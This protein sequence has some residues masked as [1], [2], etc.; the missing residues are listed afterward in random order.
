MNIYR[1]PYLFSVPVNED[2]HCVVNPLKNNAIRV[3]NSRQFNTL[4]QI[5]KLILQD[6]SD[7][8]KQFV[9]IMQQDEFLKLSNDFA[10]KNISSNDFVS[11]W[12]HTTDNCNLRCRYCYIGTKDSNIKM[13]ETVIQELCEKIRE[14]AV[15]NKF[16]YVRL[17]LAGGEPFLNY[18]IWDCFLSKLRDNL[19]VIGCSLKI[20]FLTNLTLLDDNILMFIKKHNISVSVSLDGIGKYNDNNRITK[21][22]IGTFETIDINIEK[23]LCNKISPF[24]NT[25]VTDKNIEGLPDLTKYVIQKNLSIRF[26]IVQDENFNYQKAMTFFFQCYKLFEEAIN[27]GYKFSQKHRLCDISLYGNIDR[28]CACGKNCGT[29]YSNGDIYFCQLHIGSDNKSGNIFQSQDLLDIIRKGD[30]NYGKL[31]NDCNNCAY[32]YICAGGCPLSRISEKSPSCIFFRQIIPELYRL[33]GVERLKEIDDY[34]KLNM[35]K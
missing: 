6:N 25:V 9:T 16:K 34:I 17:K 10:Y 23:L 29:I 8:L 21:Q 33:I 15:C 11:L 35:I 31:N 12:I 7:E 32:R 2:F 27:Q 30:H 19:S 22:G 13:N 26:S 20:T 5:D 1:N 24:I 28:V 3:L 14:S 4:N 18:R